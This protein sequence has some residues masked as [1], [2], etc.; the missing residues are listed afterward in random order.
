M[1]IKELNQYGE[2]LEELLKLVNKVQLL[3]KY[4]F[5][6]YLCNNYCN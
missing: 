3:G 2:R 6:T 4:I 5:Q 1:D